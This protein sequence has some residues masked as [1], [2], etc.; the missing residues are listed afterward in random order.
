MSDQNVINKSADQISRI[1][2]EVQE[3]TIAELY[4]LKGNRSTEE[5]IRL[6]ENLD[7]QQIVRLKSQNA[8]NIFNQTHFTLLGSI[9]GFADTT[10]QTLQTLINYNEQSLLSTLDNMGQIVKKEVVQGLI[11]GQGVEGVLNAVR[12]QG[13]LSEAQLRTLVDTAMN[14]YSRSVTK[15]MMDEMPDDTLYIYIGA[16]DEKTRDKCLQMMEVGEMTKQQIN[17]TFGS[18]VFTRGGGYNCRHKWEISTQT[19]FAHDP[20]KA[21]K[22][23][24]KNGKKTD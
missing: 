11:S 18:E 10:E 12:S 21:S 13:S 6:I 20:E 3:K 22:L 5:F 9:E 24:S 4:A 15:I 17:D 8:V 14:E 19:K 1:L 23:R 7:I 16:L 2:L